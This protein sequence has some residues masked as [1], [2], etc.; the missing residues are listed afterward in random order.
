MGFTR[1]TRAQL[2]VQLQHKWDDSPFWS[3]A[4]ANQVLNEALLLWGALTGYWRK[5]I[6]ITIP[7]GDAYGAIPGT[8]VQGTAVTI[9]TQPLVP[10][11][12]Y[13][14]SMARPNWRSETIADGGDV[15][16]TTTIWAPIALNAIVVWP[17]STANQ[18]AIV[19]G[20]RQ[21]PQLTADGSFLDADDSVVSTLLG[22]ALHA[23]ALKAPATVLQRTQSYQEAFLQAA[24]LRN[25][26]L[27]STRWYKRLVQASRQRALMPIRVPA[28]DDSGGP[29]GL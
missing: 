15:P 6:S 23:A 1:Y 9:G 16:S 12:L 2:R 28:P 25:G 10:S 13:G 21:T 29:G 19:N 5:Q 27:R 18:T 22:Y 17:A 3:D 7:A 8:L 20:I 11:S 4:D 24:V 26:A 14:L